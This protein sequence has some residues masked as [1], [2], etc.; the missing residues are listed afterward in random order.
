MLRAFWSSKTAMIA[1]QEKLDIISNNIS[2]IGTTGYKKAE[3]GF[4]DLLSESLDKLGYPIIDNTSVIGTGS[5]TTNIYRNDRQGNLIDTGIAT[6]L[7]ID[8]EG[9]F[10]VVA[11]DGTTYFTRSGKF[12]IDLNGNLVTDNG[13]YLDIKYENGFSI[14]NIDLDSKNMLINKSG[15]ILQKKNDSYVKV[16]SIPVYTAIGTEAFIPVGE[17]LYVQ[18]PNIAVE[19]SNDFSIYQGYLENSNVDISEEFTDM[20]ITQRAF[21]L[22]SKGMQTADDMWGMINNLRG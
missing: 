18:N 22:A 7:A 6:D 5:K 1:N 9:Y 14:N 16:G 21:Q 12:N 19:E 11:N 4:K 17:S 3:V 8:G 20:I 2:N 13:L 10:K 15:E